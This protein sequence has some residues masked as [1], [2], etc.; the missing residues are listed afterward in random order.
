[1]PIEDQF[2]S[3]AEF[4]RDPEVWRKAAMLCL[5]RALDGP[6]LS[7][8]ECRAKAKRELSL[9]MPINTPRRGQG[10]DWNAVASSLI[11]AWVVIAL[12]GVWNISSW[13]KEVAVGYAILAGLVVLV[14]GVHIKRRNARRA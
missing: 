12:A 3:R 4:E 7:E 9:T 14:V 1:M 8:A 6:G 10:T 2:L 13:P 5:L 11:A